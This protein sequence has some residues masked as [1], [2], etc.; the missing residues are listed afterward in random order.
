LAKLIV[1]PFRFTDE[2]TNI[3]GRSFRSFRRIEMVASS[4]WG[5]IMAALASIGLCMPILP[6][7]AKETAPLKAPLV[8]DVELGFGGLLVGRLLDANGRPLQDAEV[9]I[10]TGDKQLAATRTD[11]E[12]V[13]A[14]SNLRGGVHQITTADSVQLCRLWAPGTAPPQAAKSIDVIS[15]SATIR[16]QYG[17][18]PG[19]RLLRKAKVWATNPFVVGGVVAAAV[20]IPVALSDNDGPSS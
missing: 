20:A 18:P 10:L 14:V 17:P 15:D 11:A 3:R 16:G 12:G 1:L 4:R 6:A 13:F 8:R 9:S 7:S 5:R 2:A 19:N